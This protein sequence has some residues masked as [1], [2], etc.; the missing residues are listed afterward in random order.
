MPFPPDLWGSTGHL[1]SVIPKPSGSLL[2]HSLA[3]DF[4]LPEGRSLMGPA[5]PDIWYVVG[6]P[7][8]SDETSEALFGI[9]TDG[10]LC[11]Q[12]KSWF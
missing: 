4:G 11:S 8:L 12:G 9:L 3:M 5:Y 7:Y 2:S 6:T 10:M 1:V